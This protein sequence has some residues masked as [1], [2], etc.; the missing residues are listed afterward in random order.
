[1][2]ALAAL[3]RLAGSEPSAGELAELASELEIDQLGRTVGKQDQYVSAHGGV[4]ALTFQPDDRVEVRALELAAATL[5]ALRHRFL[6]FYTGEERSA[7]EMFGHQVSRT[8]GG[9]M[10]MAAN[11]E[12]TKELAMEMCAALEG[13]AL[14]RCAGLMGEQWEVKR[15]RGPGVVTERIDQLRGVALDA[16]AD[17]VSL[18]GAGGGGFLLVYAEEPEAVRAALGKAQAPE[19]RFEAG[20]PGCTATRF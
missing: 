3:R 5:D 12:R 9:D 11:L 8:H 16:G 13:G 20:A 2:C 6:L 14:E 17:G 15:E 1:V 19:L 10:A 4:C 18:M 7:A